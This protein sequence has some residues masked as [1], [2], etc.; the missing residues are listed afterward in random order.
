MLPPAG[1]RAR[2]SAPDARRGRGRAS[3]RLACGRGQAIY[4]LFEFHPAGN[5]RECV[6]NLRKPAESRCKPDRLPIGELSRM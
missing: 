2:E 3:M 4:R 6:A 5:F 1:R